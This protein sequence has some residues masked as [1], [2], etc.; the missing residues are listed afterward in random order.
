MLKIQ[1]VSLCRVVW[2]EIRC[3]WSVVSRRVL[4]SGDTH[5]RLCTDDRSGRSPCSVDRCSH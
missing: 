2:E 5:C 3:V 4:V 1:T